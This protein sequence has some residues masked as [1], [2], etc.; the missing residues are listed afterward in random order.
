MGSGCEFPVNSLAPA[1]FHVDSAG[2]DATLQIL[3]AILAPVACGAMTLALPRRLIAARVMLAAMGPLLAL[4]ILG[5]YVHMQGLMSTP[6]AIAWMP[7]FQLNLDFKPD[8]LGIFFA[9]LVASFGLLIVLYARAYFGPDRDSLYRFY[10]SLLLFMTAMLGLVLADNFMLMLLFWELTAVS[11]FLL[12]GWERDDPV[13]VK[14]AMQA[15]IT[16]GAGGL[17]LMAGLILIGVITE[18]WTFTDLNLASAKGLL[19]GVDGRLLTVA[20][21][22]IV[23]GAAA[24]SA[25]WPLHYWLPGAMAAPTP[26][27]AYLHSATMVKAGVYLVDRLWPILIDL[28]GEPIANL[29]PILLTTGAITMA[30]GGYLALRK[31]D[32]KQIFAYTTVSQLGLLMCVYGLT[33][34]RV[35][36]DRGAEH[37]TQIFNHAL[38]KAPLFLLAGAIGHIAATRELPMLRGYFRRG[39]VEKITALLLIA[40]AYAMA[41][42]PGSLGFVAK[43]FF[44][45]QVSDEVG[46]GRH[47]LFYLLAGAAIFAGTMNVA[48][49][50][51]ITST[52]LARPTQGNADGPVEPD[53]FDSE[54]NANVEAEHGRPA[55]S[56]AHPHSHTLHSSDGHHETG[57]WPAMLWLPA[58]FIL[59]FQYLGGLA[60]SMYEHLFGWLEPHR[61]EFE[62]L[63]SAIALITHP[64]VPLL[65]TIA[66]VVLGVSLGF[67]PFLRRTTRDSHDRIFPA[68]YKLATVGAGS[69]FRLI[70]RGNSTFYI[71]AVSLAI[72]ALFGW[73]VYR[74]PEA[75]SWPTTAVFEM[76]GGIMAGVIIGALICLASVMLVVLRDRLARVLMLGACGFA[77]TAFYYVYRAIDLAITQI[78]IEIISLVLFLVVLAVVPDSPDT[79]KRPNPIARLAISG[80]VGSVMFWMVLTSTGWNR[81]ELPYTGVNGEP[82]AGLGNYFLRN[83]KEAIDA[84]AVPLEK[85]YGGVQQRGLEHLSGFNSSMPHLTPEQA[86]ES[87]TLHKGGG[88]NNSVNVAIVD[89]RG[90]DT[91]GEIAVLGLAALGV[92]ALLMRVK[93][94]HAPTAGNNPAL[95]T[96]A[97]A[98]ANSEATR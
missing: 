3:T 36:S 38:Y 55:D 73:S 71:G 87:I 97:G 57:F 34:Y 63:P 79:K 77:V 33:P 93:R 25:Q 5:Q 43:E 31:T 67:S 60:P 64:S 21:T 98:D 92:W 6:E 66:C 27:S 52:L 81:P 16:T 68:F 37:I 82:I 90:F 24:K 28:G 11:S 1:S 46:P 45:Y 30:L 75:L 88:G 47:W 56:H 78:S 89:F 41:A 7:A 58:A 10:P 12:I 35:A 29:T 72:V 50:V 8:N 83:T 74:I 85:A 32:L 2:M 96:N 59:V 44:F 17:C 20:L 69:V 42:G 76:R 62:S 84:R 15:F 48:I 86:R 70:Q 80:L 95:P 49:F 26:V 65:M 9:L 91:M 54:A 13:A 51:R 40:A 4:V 23:I 61:S 19:A 18:Q 14:K 22:L 94:R 53:A 39:G